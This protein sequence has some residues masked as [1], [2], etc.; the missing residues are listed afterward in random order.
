M[1]FIQILDKNTKKQLLANWQEE[2]P[3]DEISVEDSICS[4]VFYQVTDNKKRI[5]WVAYSPVPGFHILN[6]VFVN[7]KYRGNG[8][9]KEIIS[10]STNLLNISALLLSR[11]TP[12]DLA[13]YEKLYIACGF[14]LFVKGLVPG[15][16]CVAEFYVKDAKSTLFPIGPI[17][18]VSHDEITQSLGREPIYGE[19]MMI[20]IVDII[21]RKKERLNDH[22]SI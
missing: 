2:N 3:D 14:S 10:E 6:F 1:K 5:G 12:E 20:D 4:N 13:R 15:E 18:L 21:N 11:C 9:M 19:K 7:K 22:N 8:L 17:I 16:G